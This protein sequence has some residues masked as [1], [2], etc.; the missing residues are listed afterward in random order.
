MPGSEPIPDA[1][2]S[3]SPSSSANPDVVT[4]SD[5]TF[6]FKNLPAGLYMIEARAY[7]ANSWVG[8]E[9]LGVKE[10]TL[11]V[12]SGRL[13]GRVTQAGNA[14]AA[15][16]K[17]I[18][19][20]FG[21]S[22]ARM[23]NTDGD[24]NYL[25]SDLA[26]GRWEVNLVS[27]K[28]SLLTLHDFVTMPETGESVEK[29]F[30]F[31]A[32]SLVVTVLDAAGK[33]APNVQVRARQQAGLEAT[34]QPDARIATTNSNGEARLANLTPGQYTAT[35]EGPQST[36]A[37][38]EGVNIPADGEGRVTLTLTPGAGGTLVSTAINYESGKPVPTAWCYL[39]RKDGSL[40]E[41]SAQRDELGVMTIPGIEPGDYTMEVSAFGYS[42]SRKPVTIESGQTRSETDVLYPSGALRW[43][44]KFSDGSPAAGV[45]CRLMPSD[46]T[47]VE[48]PREGKS[49]SDGV[50]SERGLLPGTY[51]AIANAPGK[52][53]LRQQVQIYAA[54]ATDAI[55]AIP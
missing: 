9:E 44:L 27:L 20:G 43:A 31:P 12:G 52:A 1:H 30:S 25:I 34:L 29:N 14:A 54:N 18:K 46:A 24:G 10:V 32:G 48:Q 45:P 40:F 21:Q 28:N 15:S 8:I 39:F 51:T 37:D 53:E 35:A 47:S 22:V 50:Y 55:G 7:A 42:I 38:A 13:S 23:A 33:P 19:L 49:N 16:V 4:I 6:E 5:G 36:R 3:I 11:E 2:I 41:H 26:P 17:V